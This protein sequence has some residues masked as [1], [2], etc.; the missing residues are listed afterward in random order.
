[1]K[2]FIAVPSLLFACRFVTLAVGAEV[3]NLRGSASIVN[4]TKATKLRQQAAAAARKAELLRQLADIE[5]QSAAT[6]EGA[7]L[8]GS[9][10]GSKQ[11]TTPPPM[12][13]GIALDKFNL[14]GCWKMWIVNG[15]WGYNDPTNYLLNFQPGANLSNPALWGYFQHNAT[16]NR[17][18][19]HLERF[20]NPDPPPPFPKGV[21]LERPCSLV[22]PNIFPV[23]EKGDP[24]LVDPS[25]CILPYTRAAPI[26]MMTC[27]T[28]DAIGDGAYYFY[29]HAPKEGEP[30]WKYRM[31]SYYTGKDVMGHL[32]ASFAYEKIDNSTDSSACWK[33]PP[34]PLPPQ[35]PGTFNGYFNVTSREKYFF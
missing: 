3:S 7:D 1:M 35:Q 20:V 6:G 23:S 11:E 26:V 19:L 10:E 13:E 17:N 29:L 8:E 15:L 31:S 14:T 18:T 2:L 16:T 25:Q 27:Y 32:G 24:C 22:I 30:E 33:P 5:D 4:Q 9:W 12:P 28:N 34:L 21:S